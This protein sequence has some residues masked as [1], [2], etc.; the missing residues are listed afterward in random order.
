[1]P[2][3]KPGGFV[4]IEIASSDPERTKKFFEDVFE[5]EFESHPEMSYHTFMPQSGPGGGLMS[6]MENQSPG[7]LNYLMSHSI[8]QD[9]KKIEQAGG[10]L[11]QPKMEIPGVGWWALFQ[12]PSGLTLALFEAKPAPAPRPPRP[13]ARTAARRGSARKASKGK[14]KGRGRKR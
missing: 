3:N 4:H 14:T 9:V 7:I 13:R 2:E 8:D 10:R 5:W 1:M 12:E 11:L 6:P